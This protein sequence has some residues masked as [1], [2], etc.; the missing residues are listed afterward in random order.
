MHGTRSRNIFEARQQTGQSTVDA[1]E[2]ISGIAYGARGAVGGGGLAVGESGNRVGEHTVALAET[3][4]SI[5]RRARGAVTG[6]GDLA[7]SG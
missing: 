6:A 4:S 3:V 7:V 1:T 2:L 5:T